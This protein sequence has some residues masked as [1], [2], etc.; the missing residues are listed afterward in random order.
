M[1]LY[2]EKNNTITKAAGRIQRTAYQVLLVR[3]KATKIKGKLFVENGQ[4]RSNNIVVWHC[5]KLQSF[6]WLEIEHSN[7]HNG[8]GHTDEPLSWLCWKLQLSTARWYN[9]WFSNEKQSEKTFF[10]NCKSKEKRVDE[11][12]THKRFDWR[13]VWMSATCFTSVTDT[14]PSVLPWTHEA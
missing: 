13:C 3:Y 7:T 9:V 12:C 14:G 4:C 6:I 10:H 1:S 5:R 11:G 8:N 2:Q